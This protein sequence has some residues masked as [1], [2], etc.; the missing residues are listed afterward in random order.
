MAL[1]SA[2]PLNE[3]NPH[4]LRLS[5]T[6]L[7]TRCGVVNSGLRGMNVQAGQWYDATFYARKAVGRGVGLVFSLES[8]NGKVVCARTTLPEVGTQD[9]RP[10]TLALH[11][12]ASDPHCRLV[13]IP[14]EPCTIWLD[15]VSL[16]PRPAAK[17]RPDDSRRDPRL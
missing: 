6:N 15:A 17:D 7:G 11:A 16:V 14:I 13:I 2:E 3:G 8:T 1:D 10:Y 5:V 12:Y 4:S 9:W